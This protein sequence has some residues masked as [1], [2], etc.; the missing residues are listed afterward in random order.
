AA[1]LSVTLVPALMVLFVRGRIIPEH[2]NPL[3]R[4]LIWVYRPVIRVVLRA[5]VLTI[6]LAVAAL[7]LTIWP[8]R[9]LGS[10]FMPD[11]NEGTLMYMP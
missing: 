11:L 10:E 1:L 9:Q 2:R 8:A 6:L 4:L 3:N 7:G 5:K